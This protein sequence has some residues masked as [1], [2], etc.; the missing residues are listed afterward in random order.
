MLNQKFTYLIG[1]EVAPFLM[2]VDQYNSKRR[3]FW[4]FTRQGPLGTERALYRHGERCAL[5]LFQHIPQNLMRYHNCWCSPIIETVVS[6]MLV[7]LVF[8]LPSSFSSLLIRSR[9]VFCQFNN[10]SRS[11]LLPPGLL[12][13]LHWSQYMP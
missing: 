11:S 3:T 6:V 8:T 2:H 10:M 4:G 12:P 9:L 5:L 13:Y 7:F 1:I